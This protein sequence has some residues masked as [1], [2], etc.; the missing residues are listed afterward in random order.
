MTDAGKFGFTLLEILVAMTIFSVTLLTLFST[1]RTVSTSSDRLKT[2]IRRHERVQQCLN[3]IFADL[4][5]TYLPR[6]PRYHPPDFNTPADPYR[7][8][9]TE[10]G[11]DGTF[12]SRL[13]FASLNHLDLGPGFVPGA[14]RIQYYVHQQDNRFNLHRF[15]GTFLSDEG[16]DP[17]TDP[18]LF[19]DI[20]TF[21]VTFTD[22]DGT[23]HLAWDS[24]S[25]R[26]EYSVPARITIA[27]APMENS[28]EEPIQATVSLPVTREVTQ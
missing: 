26:F 25:D 22:M 4:E 7:F 14:G 12:F 23:E 8:A 27:V 28:A 15:D 9:G 18:V 2:D 20:H 24:E 16:P 10:T 5:Q 3:I 11:V 21:S 13:E 17:C 19:K 1:F 6:P